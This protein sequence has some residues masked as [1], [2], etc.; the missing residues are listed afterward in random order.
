MTYSASRRRQGVG[1]LDAV[2]G[3]IIL[4]FVVAGVS[5][6]LIASA[7]TIGTSQS[8][9]VATNL[10]DSAVAQQRTTVLA[11]HTLPT[12]IALSAATPVTIGPV[13]NVSYTQ[14]TGV[15]W[16]SLVSGTWTAYT[17]ASDPAAYWV[18]VKVAWGDL[19]TY[20]VVTGRVPTPS[21]DTPPT[22]PADILAAT[23][24]GCPAQ[25]G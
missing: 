19:S 25:Q 15:G 21:G 13:G 18:A 22:S 6:Q 23:T 12:P 11:N 7:L 17:S 3:S 2:V 8:S 5:T 14:W 4:L 10:A 24:A 9:F 1:L 16:C 20:R